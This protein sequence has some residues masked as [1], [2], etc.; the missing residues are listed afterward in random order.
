MEIKFSKLETVSGAPLWVLNMPF[1]ESVAAGVFVH[2]GK[3]YYCEARK[4]IFAYLQEKIKQL[5][6]RL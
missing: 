2:T 4:E 3:S 1:A 5:G 6:Y